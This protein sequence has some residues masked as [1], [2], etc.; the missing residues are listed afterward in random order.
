VLTP[1]SFYFG[2]TVTTLT[3]LV[4]GGSRSVFGAVVGALAVAGV[5]EVLRSVEEGASL[6]GLISIG[7]TPGLAAIGLGLILL[8]TMVA[9]PDGLTGGREAGE[10]PRRLGRGE[11]GDAAGDLLKDESRPPPWRRASG[12]LQ[13]EGIS[14]AF[15]GLRV[16]RDVGLELRQGEALGLI[17]PNGAGKTTLVNV[18]SGFLKPDSGRVMLDG[19]DVTSWKPERLA[20]LGLGR[21]FQAVLAFGRLSALEGVAMGA[22]ATGLGKREAVKRAARLLEGLGLEAEAGKTAG[23]LPPGKQRLL[24][25][26]RALATAPRYLLLDEPAAGLSEA[27]REDLVERLGPL[28]A[29]FGCGML[30]IEHDIG[31]VAGLCTRVQVI[32][33][34]STVAIGSPAEVQADPAVIESYLG[35]GFLAGA[36]A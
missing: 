14:V 24:G 17:G 35:S 25:V 11:D 19:L 1:T 29:Q 28:A 20:R 23:S 12:S 9:M 22:M 36:G 32:D 8:G 16:L 3:M 5:N 18:L 26:A 2:A 34:G 15:A 13:A 21:S 33:D 31:V 30:V 7:E 10:L 4:V 6:F 27:E